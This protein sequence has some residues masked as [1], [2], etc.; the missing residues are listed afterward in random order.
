MVACKCKIEQLESQLRAVE[1]EAEAARL[2]ADVAQREADE[3][4]E[5]LKV[6][7][8]S[9]FSLQHTFRPPEML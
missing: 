3:L 2:A 8:L 1:R 7:M 9:S 6:L 4:S 5:S